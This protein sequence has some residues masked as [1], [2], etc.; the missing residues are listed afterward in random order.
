MPKIKKSVNDENKCP[1]KISVKKKSKSV[2]KFD[3]KRILKERQ[4]EGEF[5]KK[6][7]DLD[8]EMKV[9]DDLFQEEVNNTIKHSDKCPIVLPTVGYIVFDRSKYNMNFE[10]K[11]DMIEPYS[12]QLLL[13]SIEK[14]ELEANIIFNNLMK[15]NWSPVFEDVQ[16]I[17]SN[18]G[19]DLDSLTNSSLLK[20]Q[21]NY[22]E[23]IG[24]HNFELVINFISYKILKN[25]KEFSDDELLTLAQYIVKIS[26]DNHCGQMINVIKRL[27]SACIET[28]LQENDDTSIIAFAQGL[29]SQYNYKLLKMVVDLF[30][31]LEGNT[32][33]KMYTYLTFKLFK[34]L[35]EKTNDIRSFPSNIN[36][37]FVQDLVNKDFFNKKPKRL[38]YRLIRLLEHVVIVFDLYKD[39]KKLSDMYDFLNY[40]VKPNGLSDSL[41]LVNILDQWRLRLFRLH[42][43][44]KNSLL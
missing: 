21:I 10:N 41:K 27:F 25:N 13:M 28:A 32:M 29:Y 37:W 42:V 23:K 8:K 22:C 14:N 7:A 26:F 15:S 31:P 43:N 19:A 20:C 34:S 4:A 36:E 11:S 5:W 38:I 39:E 12:Q 30:L 9:V 33:K 24:R 3:M 40:V 44:R 6:H 16:Y 35:L 1:S 18:W 17:F 2:F